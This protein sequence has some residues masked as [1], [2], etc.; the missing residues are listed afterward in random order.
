MLQQELPL[1]RQPAHCSLL[2]G[3]VEKMLKVDLSSSPEGC[4]PPSPAPSGG[5]GPWP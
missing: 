2:T 3:H 5:T 4:H 1:E